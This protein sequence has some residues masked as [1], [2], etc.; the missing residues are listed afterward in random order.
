MLLFV[1][2]SNIYLIFSVGARNFHSRRTRK[3]KSAPKIGEYF[4]RR[5]ME[6]IYVACFR[7]VC[8]GPSALGMTGTSQEPCRDIC[9]IWQQWA[10]KG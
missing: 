4:R 1:Y 6:S 5:K 10:S 8:H 2:L 7:S 9:A 3:E